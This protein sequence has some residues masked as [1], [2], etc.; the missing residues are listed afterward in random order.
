[1]GVNT[2]ALQVFV[3]KTTKE[4]HIRQTT[5]T[6]PM[7]SVLWTVLPI[8]VG[9]VVTALFKAR[10]VGSYMPGK[11]S[12]LHLVGLPLQVQIA[13]ASYRA[14]IIAW[15]FSTAVGTKVSTLCSGYKVTLDAER[16]IQFPIPPLYLQLKDAPKNDAEKKAIEA[17]IQGFGELVNYRGKPHISIPKPMVNHITII[18]PYVKPTN[19][20][21]ANSTDFLGVRSFI[22]TLKFLTLF[23]ATHTYPA[24]LTEDASEN[25]NAETYIWKGKTGSMIYSQND[26]YPESEDDKNVAGAK[27]DLS[28][29]KTHDYLGSVENPTGSYLAA[30]LGQAAVVAKPSPFRPSKNIGSINDVPALPG[31]S[32]PYFDGMML[33][34]HEFISSIMQRYFYRGFGDTVETQE[35]EFRRWK[36]GAKNWAKSDSGIALNH[37]FLCM[38]AAIEAQARLFIIMSSGRYI[39]S[40]ILGC[41]FHLVFQGKKIARLT[42]EQISVLLADMDIHAET[43]KKIC[44]ILSNIETSAGMTQE[45]EPNS[46]G[47]ALDI[48]RLILERKILPADLSKIEEKL[49]GLSFKENLKVLGESSLKE[50]LDLYITPDATHL[51]EWPFHLCPGLLNDGSLEARLLQG[52]GAEAPSF[53]NLTGTKYKIPKIDEED[54]LSKLDDPS[55]GEKSPKVMDSILVSMKKTV[56]AVGDFR[57]VLKERNIKQNLEERAGGNRNLKLGGPI[58]DRIWSRLRALPIKDPKKRNLDDDAETPESKKNKIAEGLDMTSF[59]F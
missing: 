55:K 28:L 40:L 18:L 47:S 49:S 9:A 21:P 54:P 10:K 51:A 23:L 59:E 33:E 50:F 19:P 32:L 46:I 45:V 52:F 5:Q 1:M 27:P 25:F 41:R 17:L 35:V 26:V 16:L 34:D 15:M 37:I 53:I 11:A 44:G 42:A 24:Y 57:S 31:Y 43:V 20:T 4:A 7:A 3:K 30:S 6:Y 39:G 8:A 38:N 29:L 48:R 58:R 22:T 14:N 36:E 2:T 56:I 13:Y 12:N